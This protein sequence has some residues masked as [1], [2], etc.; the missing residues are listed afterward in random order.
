MAVRLVVM[1]VVFFGASSLIS[2]V[3]PATTGAPFWCL[4]LGL[5]FATLALLLY[6]GAVRLTER[7]R[8]I[9]LERAD[10]PRGLFRGAG[11]GLLLF[12]TTIA[13]IALFGGT[14][15]PAPG[16]CGTRRPRWA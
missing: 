9:E 1:L 16:R 3:V 13:L 5:V 8:I 4:V 6:A 14:G 10:A 12:T 7:R 11:V 2:L 15:S